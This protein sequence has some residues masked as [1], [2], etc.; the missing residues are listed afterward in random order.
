MTVMMSR[1]KTIQDVVDFGMCVGCGACHYACDHGAVSLINVPTVGIR[2]RFN[3]IVC[4]S[5]TECL[6]ICPGH[7][8]DGDEVMAGAARQTEADHEFGPTLEIWEGYAA[9]PEIRF[10]GSSGGL[11]SALSLFCLERKDMSF[12]LHAGMD[13]EKPWLNKTLRSFN[14]ED[15]MKRAGSRYAPASPCDRLA[16]VER[17][18]RPCVFIGKPCDT[19]AVS[20]LRQER[21]ELDRKLGL[22]MTFF[23]AGAPATQGTLDLLKSLDLSPEEIDTLRYRGEGWPGR[24]RALYQGRK[25]DRSMSYEESWGRLTGYRSMRCNLCPDG[26]G[27]VADISCGDAWESHR[28]EGQDAGRS[29]VL[30]RTERGRA[31]VREAIEAG[32]VM[33]EP[34]SATNVLR[35]QESLLQ[36]RRVLFGRLIALKAFRIPVTQ[37]QNFS[38][39]RSWLKISIVS[40]TKSVLGT[41]RRILRRGLW[42]RKP[43]FTGDANAQREPQVYGPALARCGT[44]ERSEQR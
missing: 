14:R 40:Q 37:F 18:E 3:T 9:D 1:A 12:V 28:K 27:R 10:K 30:V 39:L 20:R 26:L 25:K 44:A 11:L 19:T 6:P 2:P 42:R 15:L 41:M 13:E 16:E 35:A 24:F 43:L 17:S 33:L 32:Y 4:A 21:P 29:I 34:I 5:C 31:I 23:C 8:V 38:L 22:V 36:R 7:F